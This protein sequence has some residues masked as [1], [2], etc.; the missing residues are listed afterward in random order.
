M[1]RAKK[2]QSGVRLGLTIAIK[3]VI[4]FAIGMLFEVIVSICA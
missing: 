2:T 1:L 4:A 3:A